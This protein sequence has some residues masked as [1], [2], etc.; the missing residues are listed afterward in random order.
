MIRKGRGKAEMIKVERMTN[1]A[2]KTR[3]K[4]EN[5]VK[6]GT[7]S[8]KLCLESLAG[9]RREV[10]KRKRS[11]THQKM[12]FPLPHRLWMKTKKSLRFLNTAYSLTL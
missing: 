10:P 9:S 11:M 4:K 1:M 2:R 5:M 8:G 6:K 7:A 3:G 12:N